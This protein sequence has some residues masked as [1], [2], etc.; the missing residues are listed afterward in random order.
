MFWLGGVEKHPPCS[1]HTVLQA[2]SYRVKTFTRNTFEKTLSFPE[3]I[4]CCNVSKKMSMTIFSSYDM[5]LIICS[6]VI[7]KII[8]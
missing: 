6:G 7:L 1:L 8:R 3:K 4:R 5:I 2:A